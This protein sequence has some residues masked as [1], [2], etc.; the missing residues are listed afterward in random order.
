MRTPNEARPD[1][2]RH[3]RQGNQGLK[4]EYGDG[5][6]LRCRTRL[7]SASLASS[8]GVSGDPSVRVADG[9]SWWPCASAGSVPLSTD[10]RL[11]SM[12]LRETISLRRLLWDTAVSMEI[13][14]PETPSC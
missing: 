12:E 10:D 3:P 1:G 7:N 13:A 11:S 5:Y 9:R 14:A 2:S 8:A 6:R 4:L